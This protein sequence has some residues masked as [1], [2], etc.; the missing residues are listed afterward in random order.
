MV[1]LL[2]R[3][4]ELI[5]ITNDLNKRI[6]AI[7]SMI[8]VYSTIDYIRVGELMGE[9]ISLNNHLLD[10]LSESNDLWLQSIKSK[11]KQAV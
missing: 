4:Q 1:T 9:R 3:K 7:D 11:G 5:A 10:V 8:E 2:Q 6:N